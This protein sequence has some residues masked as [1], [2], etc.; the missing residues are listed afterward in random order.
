VSELRRKLS[1]DDHEA[2]V[3]AIEIEAVPTG[4]RDSADILRVGDL[5]IWYAGA[6][7]PVQAVDGVSFALRPGE[8]LGLVGES[9]CG[10]STLGRGLMG[11]SRAGRLST[12]S[13]S[14][15]AP[16]CC[17]CNTKRGRGYVAPE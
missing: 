3:S 9:G 13:W 4:T 2:A 16:I 5:R 17:G 15:P 10:K 11:C 12:V 1:R 6:K 7:G 14:L 8:V